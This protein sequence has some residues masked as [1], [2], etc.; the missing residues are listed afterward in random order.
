MGPQERI[1]N[2]VK[3]IRFKLP[4]KWFMEPQLRLE[5]YLVE[6]KED[7][8]GLVFLVSCREMVNPIGKHHKL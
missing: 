3:L 5:T 8:A 7:G 6:L 4:N 2:N 1:D